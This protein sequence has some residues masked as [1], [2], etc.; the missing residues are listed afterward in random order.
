M[1]RMEAHMTENPADTVP[2]HEP[3]DT[4]LTLLATGVPLTLIL[5]LAL[6]VDSRAIYRDEPA[7]VQWVPSLT[8]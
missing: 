4:A 7:D 1:T 3:T 5:D 2:T 8:A 6:A